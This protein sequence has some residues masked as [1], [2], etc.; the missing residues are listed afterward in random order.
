MFTTSL[1][2][3]TVDQATIDHYV[4]RG[5][6]LRSRAFADFFRALFSSAPDVAATKLAKAARPA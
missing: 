5:S 4:A 2:P 6:R 3:P 1:R